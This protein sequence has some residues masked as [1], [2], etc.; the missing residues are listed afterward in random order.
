MY[1]QSY[2]ETMDE[3]CVDDRLNEVEALTIVISKLE[4]AKAKGAQSIE[5]VD[6]LFYTRRLWTFFMESLADDANSLPASLRA[7]LISI[8]IWIIKE[9]ERLRYHEVESFDD[10]IEINGMIRD[11]LNG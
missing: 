11:S 6:A 1:T 7:E 2:A 4:A 3:I 9:V 10:L 8:G 5:A